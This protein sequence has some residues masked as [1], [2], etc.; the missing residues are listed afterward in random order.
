MENLIKMDDLRVPL[1]SETPIWRVS[2]ASPLTFSGL[3]VMQL[4]VQCEP[5][6]SPLLKADEFSPSHGMLR[7]LFRWKFVGAWYEFSS[8]VFSESYHRHVQDMNFLPPV[9]NGFAGF[10]GLLMGYRDQNTCSK[11]I[12]FQCTDL[13]FP[14]HS[15]QRYQ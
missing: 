10:R 3:L 13:L 1:F 6:E 12:F 15:D 5:T 11:Y 7:T 4:R 2:L 14:I 8:W 9:S